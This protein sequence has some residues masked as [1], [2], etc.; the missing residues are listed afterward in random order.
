[1]KFPGDLVGTLRDTFRIAKLTLSA[2]GLTASRTITVPDKD[3]TLY[4]GSKTIDRFTW[5][6]AEPP[7]SNFASLDTRNSQA[8]LAF[9]DTTEESVVFS[10]VIPD[11]ADLASGLKIRIRWMSATATTGNVRWGVQIE[12][13][14]TDSDADSFDTAFEAHTA[15][16]GTSGSRVWTEITITTI[17][18]LTVGDAYRLKVYRDASDTTNDTVTGD[19]QLVRVEVQ[20]VV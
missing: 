12:R 9:D 1:M 15:T 5:V 14:N 17:D 11:G 7:A 19:A 20:T 2:S 16:S 6:H 8:C 10:G 13:D 3:F 18:S 4:P